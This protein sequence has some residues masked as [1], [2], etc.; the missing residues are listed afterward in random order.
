MHYKTQLAPARLRNVQAVSRKL[1]DGT[2]RLH[3]YHRPTRTKLLGQRDSP[4]FMESYL[5]AERIWAARREQKQVFGTIAEPQQPAQSIR[6]NEEA[7]DG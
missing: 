5:A 6:A 2:R 7:Q 1:V 4:E 3:Y